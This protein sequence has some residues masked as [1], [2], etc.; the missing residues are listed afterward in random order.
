MDSS[1]KMTSCPDHFR[2]VG[3]H[4]ESVK[5]A[6]VVKGMSLP[7]KAHICSFVHTCLLHQFP[8]SSPCA[9]PSHRNLSTYTVSWIQT[10]F[11]RCDLA[12]AGVHVPRGRKR[13]AGVSPGSCPLCL[14]GVLFV[15]LLICLSWDILWPLNWLV[16]S[17]SEKQNQW[18]RDRDR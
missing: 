1:E 6:K 4:S 12:L 2:V 7:F 5:Q 15:I 17:S 3:T 11:P 14:P 9:S 16:R 13:R 8:W 18:E 10:R